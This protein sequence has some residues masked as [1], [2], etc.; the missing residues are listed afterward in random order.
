M[1]EKPVDQ[2]FAHQVSDEHLRLI[3]R[4]LSLPE[5]ENRWEQ[6]NRAELS[7]RDREDE[8]FLRDLLSSA[9]TFRTVKG[10]YLDRDG[11]LGPPPVKTGG[12][13]ILVRF[14]PG[15]LRD[16]RNHP[17]ID[18]CRDAGGRRR[19]TGVL[20]QCPIV[21]QGTGI[22]EMPGVAELTGTQPFDH[23]T[24]VHPEAVVEPIRNDW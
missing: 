24:R 5:V 13:A 19:R 18:G 6:R 3:K 8:S 1:I 22:V 20:C 2:T 9:L 23:Q 11:Y 15:P 12:R 16:G 10:S 17:A 14:C 4:N 7:K 21:R